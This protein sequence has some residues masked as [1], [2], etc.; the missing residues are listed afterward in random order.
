MT[1]L[2]GCG[3]GKGQPAG[4]VPKSK[5]ATIAVVAPFSRESYL[6]TTIAN[7]A[8]LGVRRLIVPVGRDYYGFKVKR[9]DNAASASR[10]VAATR[11]A[12]ADHVLAIVTDGTGVDASW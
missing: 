3:G 12:I 4:Q 7:G 10:A 11:R 5:T 9:Y 8:E 1:A 2:A 6:G